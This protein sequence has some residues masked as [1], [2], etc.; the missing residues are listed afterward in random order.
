MH[1]LVPVSEGAPLV[2]QLGVHGVEGPLQLVYVLPQ[3]HVTVILV[4]LI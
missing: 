1:L 3:L 4:L 2:L